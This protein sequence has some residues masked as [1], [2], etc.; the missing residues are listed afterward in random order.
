MTAPTMSAAT[1]AFAKRLIAIAI[2]P[3]R[4]RQL[5][6]H[7]VSSAF[8]PSWLDALPPPT[9]AAPTVTLINGSDFQRVAATDPAVGIGRRTR[10]YENL[11]RH[12]SWIGH[13][14]GYLEQSV[15]RRVAC[16]AYASR[17]GDSSLGRHHDDWDGVIVQLQGEKHWSV[18]PDPLAAPDEIVTRA[19]DVLVLRRGVVHDVS[20]PKSSCHLAFAIADTHLVGEPN[21]M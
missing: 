16:A 11:D 12:V 14:A 9:T 6:V 17:A 5:S 1:L 15:G 2:P 19:G 8:N 20:T 3:L 4:S 10:S 13:A 7:H 18:W 21:V